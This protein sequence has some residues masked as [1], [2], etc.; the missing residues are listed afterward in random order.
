MNEYRKPLPQ[1]NEDTRPFWD[2]CRKHELRMQKCRQCGFIR[3]PAGMVCTRC[4]S[5]EADWVKL[6]GKGKVYTFN[7]VHY[8]Y[9]KG[10]ADDM[11]YVTAVIDLEEGPSVL[12][13]IIGCKPEQVAIDMPV[14]VVFEDINEEITLYKFQPTS[15]VS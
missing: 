7:V 2:Y 12:S 3:F 5:T 1:P 8:P 4:H 13:N 9:H 11:P 10:F 6:S 15:Q 14:E